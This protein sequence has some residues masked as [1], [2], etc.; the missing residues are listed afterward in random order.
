LLVSVSFISDAKTAAVAQLTSTTAAALLNPSFNQAYKTLAT[1]TDNLIKNTYETV[2]NSSALVNV[3]PNFSVKNDNGVGSVDTSLPVNAPSISLNGHSFI[4]RAGNA[5]FDGTVT[6]VHLKLVNLSGEI[7]HE[8]SPSGDIYAGNSLMIGSQSTSGLHSSVKLSNNTDITPKFSVDSNGNVTADGNFTTF[9]DITSNTNMYSSSTYAQYVSNVYTSSGP[10]MVVNKAIL[11]QVVQNITGGD[12]A[13]INA[14][15][16]LITAYNSSDV[17]LIETI[18]SYQNSINNN[19]LKQIDRIYT[20]LFR[21]VSSVITDASIFGTP[22]NSYFTQGAAAGI[23]AANL[24][25]TAGGA[26]EYTQPNPYIKPRGYFYTIIFLFLLLDCV[27][28]IPRENQEEN[29]Q[30]FSN[31]LTIFFINDNII[32][33]VTLIELVLSVHDN[34]R[35]REYPQIRRM[36]IC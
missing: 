24:T 31:D 9:K 19:L 25:K 17:T 3:G 20:Y 8:N 15:K 26:I 22:D 32:E 16:D 13:S 36:H 10:N 18:L 33:F 30:E 14:L 27:L 12:P 23:N 28:D 6:A 1:N 35:S 21:N 29:N 5:S 7:V 11:D 2:S 34:R 4:D